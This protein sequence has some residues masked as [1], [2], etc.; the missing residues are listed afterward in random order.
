MN[1]LNVEYLETTH[2]VFDY[3]GSHVQNKYINFITYQK[4]RES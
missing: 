4:C 1:V 3:S 2:L